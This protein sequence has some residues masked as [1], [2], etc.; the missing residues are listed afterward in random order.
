[1]SIAVKFK[2][3]GLDSLLKRMQALP[4]EIGAK[5]GGPLRRALRAGAKPIKDTAIR[6]AP[7]GRRTPS[8]GRLR[9]AMRVMADRHP[10]QNHGAT[11]VVSVYVR[12]GKKSFARG[13]GKMSARQDPNGAWYWWFV[14]N[15]T[16]KMRAQPFLRPAFESQ[17]GPALVIIVKSMRKGL[18]AAERKVK[19]MFPDRGAK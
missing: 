11:E 13:P 18:D 5:G 19:R 8:P 16:Y 1:M 7:I 3:S 6:N 2:V 12:A 14:E 15:G 17:K 10:E 9:R 4:A